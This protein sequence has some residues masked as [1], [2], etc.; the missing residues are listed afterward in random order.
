M[1][2][3]PE[4]AVRASTPPNPTSRCVNGRPSH[5]PQVFCGNFE[6]DAEER[7]IVKLFEKY[8]P[9]EKIDMK[10]GEPACAPP[11]AWL[12]GRTPIE[13]GADGAVAGHDLCDREHI[14]PSPPPPAFCTGRAR[15]VTARR[16]TCAEVS[17]TGDPYGLRT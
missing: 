6:Y 16:L 17:A 9:V 7:D 10:T 2:P 3:E 13:G 15:A 12:G 4:P 5:E 8:G 1:S 11:S 14:L